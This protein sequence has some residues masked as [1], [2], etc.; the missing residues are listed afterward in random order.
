MADQPRYT[1]YQESGFFADGT[2]ARPLPEGVIPQGF[3]PLPTTFP[4]PIS[5]EVLKRGQERYNIFCTPCHDHMGTGEGMAAR[6]GFRKMPPSF[7]NDRWRA[8]PP[9]EFFDV[10][11]HGS[12]VMPS[13]AYQIPVADRWAIVAYIRALQLSFN[14][15]P[16]DV[17]PDELNKLDREKQ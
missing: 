6:R 17:P 8:A 10:I 12:G 2:S 9:E 7:H 15:S 13:Y 16:S 14:A 1:T 3:Q 5:M 11:T 4:F